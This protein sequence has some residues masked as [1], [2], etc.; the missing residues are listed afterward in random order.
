MN[1][2]Q[3]AQVDERDSGWELSAPRF[4]VY[5]HGSGESS[6]PG[7]TAAYDITGADVLQVIDWA[8][9]Q[10][11]S[12][13][14]FAIALVH[15]DQ[16]QEQL[17]PGHVR[18]LVWLVGMDGNDQAIGNH[19]AETQRR[20]LARRLEPITVAPADQMPSDLPD[21]YNDGTRTRRDHHAHIAANTILYPVIDPSTEPR[22]AGEG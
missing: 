22:R 3:I 12:S 15:D 17:N 9:R 8:Q 20:M 21:P 19:E 5:L 4:R 1:D 18:G 2:V 11:G 10:A 7:W 6:T 13:L 16:A 14:T